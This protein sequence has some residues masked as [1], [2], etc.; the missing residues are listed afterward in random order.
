MLKQ[1]LIAGSIGCATLFTSSL[2]QADGTGLFIAGGANY[3]QLD[4]SIDDD[5][6]FDDDIEALFDDKSVGYNLGAGWRFT[7]W[8]AVD[9]AYW[10]LGEFKSDKLDN[11]EKLGFDTSIWTVGG[12]VS[13]PLWI[14]DIY[15]RAGAAMWEVDSRYIDEDGTDLYYGVGAALNVFSSI[16]L[17]LEYVRF[18]ADEAIDTAGLGVR[19]TF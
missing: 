4:T 11:G 16:D 12:I 2:A 13:A 3:A 14:L 6:D 7:K 5:I 15:G 9:A 19:W 8:L 18:D 17:Y 1:L 10:D